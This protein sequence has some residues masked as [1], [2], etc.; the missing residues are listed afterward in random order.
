[1]RRTSAAA[2]L[3]DETALGVHTDAIRSVAFSACGRWMA[4]GGDDKLFKLWECASWTCKWTM[5]AI[6]EQHDAMGVADAC[7]E[8]TPPATASSTK[9]GAV[10]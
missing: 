9:D 5:C 3:K 2:N 1:M 8:P 7:C 10:F 6:F 4:T